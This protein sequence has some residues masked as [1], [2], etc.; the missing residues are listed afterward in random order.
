M[1]ATKKS[2]KAT[3]A[4]VPVLKK[5]LVAKWEYE[6]CGAPMDALIEELGHK[7]SDGIRRHATRAAELC[8]KGNCW[9]CGSDGG[10]QV[11]LKSG[12][13]DWLNVT[14]CAC[15]L[16]LQKDVIWHIPLPNVDALENL[17]DAVLAGQ[18]S[19]ATKVVTRTC[20]AMRVGAD[21]RAGK[22]PE[23][24]TLT[25]AEY[26]AC[27]D[28]SQK[29]ARKRDAASGR[30]RTERERLEDFGHPSKCYHCWEVARKRRAAA[31]ATS[32]D[33]SAPPTRNRRHL[34]A[35]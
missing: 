34:K 23:R 5:C 11:P 3:L 16:D 22:C 12:K 21:G 28:T 14:L 4:P 15:L 29:W 27:I 30:N 10:M 1:A 17:R 13:V 19:P 2:T 25:A 8:A 26:K 20:N 24:F 18:I 31:A 32:R 6:Q 7:T 35:V 33:N 9:F